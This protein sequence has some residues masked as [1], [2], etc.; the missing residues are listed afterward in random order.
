MWPAEALKRPKRGKGLLL[1]GRL[2]ALPAIGIGR[3]SKSK[4]VRAASGIVGRGLV[5]RLLL[6]GLTPR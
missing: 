3:C 5:L 6:R 4:A 1:R 2:T